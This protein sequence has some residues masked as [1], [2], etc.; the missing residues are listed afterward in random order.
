MQKP[1]D[2]FKKLDLAHLD[3]N[4]AQFI[5]E[6]ILTLPNIDILEG[7]KEFETIKAIV[8]ENFP[9]AIGIEPKVVEV[10]PETV[11]EEVIEP[12]IDEKQVEIDS[13][14]GQVSELSSLVE[15]LNEMITENPND[16]E[17]VEVLELYNETLQDLKDKLSKLTTV[18]TEAIVE[19]KENIEEVKEVIKTDVVDNKG[20][21]TAPKKY[22]TEDGEEV[23][24]YESDWNFGTKKHLGETVVYYSYKEGI[25]GKHSVLTGI[26]HK[27]EIVYSEDKISNKEF[28]NKFDSEKEALDFAY[29]LS[30][31][32]ESID[33][34]EKGGEV[35][36][37]LYY[38]QHGIG[39]AKYTV[40]YHDGIEKHKDGSPF[41]AIRTFK[42]KKDLKEFIDSLLKQGYKYKDNAYT[43]K[44]VAVHES[45]D[46]YWTI[47][48]KPTT[49]ELAEEMLGGTP[50]NEVGKVV[51]LEE[52]RAH[53]KVVGGEYLYEKGGSVKN[54]S[55]DLIVR[56]PKELVTKK[57]FDGFTKEEIIKWG[58]D[59]DWVYNPKGE[60]LGG[61]VLKD[62]EFFVKEFKQK[63]VK[64]PKKYEEG[65]RISN[66]DKIKKS[67]G[68][69]IFNHIN[70]LNKSQLKKQLKELD[71]ELNREY[72][73]SNGKSERYK[74]LHDEKLYILHLLE[75]VGLDYK[76]PVGR[77]VSIIDAPKS[78]SNNYEVVGHQN[79]N[80]KYGWETTI[81]NDDEKITMYENQLEPSIEKLT[82][83]SENPLS[84]Q[85]TKLTGDSWNTLDFES[86]ERGHALTTMK[87]FR[88]IKSG[89]IFQV[90]N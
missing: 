11:V 65:G 67:I 55:Y 46:G 12:I 73:E 61:Q 7:T 82:I 37:K 34:F 33:K 56:T 31:D 19:T 39:K 3:A 13:I 17:S 70:S 50:K 62:Y 28:E 26:L 66:I 30:L 88:H 41:Y 18:I 8:E 27:G 14:S 64:L 86:I 68:E 35:G 21:L 40:S 81:K 45:K 48:S 16:L 72:F 5:R 60:K 87:P 75:G 6:K 79:Y 63:K 38:E 85:L 2:Y 36:N 4:T 89:R 24:G 23:L 22:K 43:T 44:Y 57:D 69:T 83:S 29:E 9:R 53:K 58:N 51:T 77:K 78:E 71:T 49:K 90:I 52:A 47:A 25:S 80:E 84:S 32:K 15:L 42:N 59:R 1:S 74:K 54:I 10:I 20:I 76:F